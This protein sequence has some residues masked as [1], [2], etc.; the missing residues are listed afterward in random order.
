MNVLI[1]SQCH[2]SSLTETRRVLD[3][4]AERKGHRTWQTTI[5]QQG[6][7]TLRK[8]LKKKAKRSTAVACYWM[9][10]TSRTDL[11]WI[12][13]R[14]SAFNEE[15]A[16]PTNITARDVLKTAD[17]NWWHTA[18]YISLLAAI[19][20]LF[21][22]FG[23]ANILFQKK[24]YPKK[25]TKSDKNYEPYRHEWVSL[26]LFQ[27]FVLSCA[28]E[29]GNVNDENWLQALTQVDAEREALMV[30]VLHQ[31]HPDNKEFV[32]PFDGLPPA[33]KA[34]AWL[35]LSHHRLPECS[36][37][38]HAPSF[39]Y[40]DTW[41]KDDF[42]A[43]WNSPQCLK[44][45]WDAKA[46]KDV[47]CFGKGSPLLSKTWQ[48]RA[49]RVAERALRR[50]NNFSQEWLNEP[51]SL[52]LA[53]LALMMADHHYSSQDANEGFQDKKY[54][55]Y[56]NTDRDTK[57]LKQRLDE[58]L[59]G[60]Y[61]HAL[62]VARVLPTLRQS[63]PAIARHPIFKKRNK[64]ERFRWQDK[65]YDVA[66]GLREQSAKHGFFGVNV[67][68]TGRGKTLGNARIMYG[69]A[70]EKLGCRFSIA[71][72]L[73]TLTLQTG[74]ALKDKLKLDDDDLAVLI[75]SQAVRQLHNLNQSEAELAKQSEYLQKS[76]GSESSEDLLELGHYVRYEGVLAGSDGP[77]HR[78]LQKTPK[79]NQ[80]VSAPILV[81]TIDHLMPATE[82]ARGG[83]QIAPMLRLL[84]SD[85]V[86]DE[87]DD[88]DLNDL[89]A[90][91]RLVH[92]AGLLGSRV[93]LSSATLPP[94][95]VTALFEAYRE[96]RRGYQA[97]CGEPNTPLNI[98]CAWFD[99]NKAIASQH[100][101]TKDFEVAHEQFMKKRCA[102]LLDDKPLRKA[103]LLPVK[104]TCRTRQEAAQRYAEKIHTAIHE[105]HQCHSVS[106]PFDKYSVSL[107]LVR[108]ANINPL[109]AVAENL[110]S[111]RSENQD[112]IQ[113]HY[114][115]Y[116]S[117]HPLFVRSAIE[118]QLDQALSRQNPESLWQQESIKEALKQYP[119][120]KHH[121]FVVLASAVAE[122][123]RDHDYDWAIAE[124]S[125]MRSLIQL[126]GRIQ[127]HR[128][129]IPETPNLLILTQNIRGLAGADVAFEKPGF[130]RK[131]CVLDSHDLQ[132]I[133][134]LEQYEVMRSMPRMQENNPLQP[135]K[136]L[137]DLE[138]SQLR[139]ELFGKV[140]GGKSAKK[141]AA[142][143]WNKALLHHFSELQ[144]QT[145]FRQSE[146]QDEFLWLLDE[147]GEE[148]VIYR[149]FKD[150]APK[151]CAS[152]FCETTPELAQGVS[153]WGSWNYQHLLVN[154]AD[155]LSMPYEKVGEAFGILR[156]R[157]VD[158]DERP[159]QYDA[160]LGYYQK[161]D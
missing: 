36:P 2:K 108:I 126:A 75:G 161:L 100:E 109:V 153:F 24:I 114:C 144:R 150:A 69:L 120:K 111:L 131:N 137:A 5:T 72:G 115:I 119:D 14:T 90:L 99:E 50:F 154:L 62:S 44:D 110:L 130:E 65:A 35:V 157:K 143:W 61:R 18:E 39:K 86:L 148:L 71:L 56:A 94:A 107:G 96:G 4:F 54:K 30:S 147:D 51:F 159:W 142:L 43:H 92:W 38:G 83:K 37:D 158:N 7:V 128:C 40:C 32:S 31:D 80:L 85:L 156:L 8:M 1:I 133:L 42:A 123:G 12:V 45:D 67:A 116:H 98:S 87:P 22:D 76:L 73:R 81:S 112:D 138:H 27:A 46:L 124:P 16:V 58:H 145:R 60:V 41:W 84:T 63:L 26:R 106:D 77:M 28:D 136:N 125:S 79:L 88:F 129:Q 151:P 78:W 93:L 103:R 139:R 29:Q 6:L 155:T 102:K 160:H 34:V 20:A 33:A 70:D 101:R 122:V 25:K 82:G 15:G 117:Q 74:D 9:R 10:G 3:H 146:P 104:G 152:E 132:Q 91:T 48:G 19:A 113:I 105:L 121:C 49:K 127:R 135:T 149:C 141:Y 17:E 66:C 55:I 52:H 23:K 11:L 53:R 140:E 64:L 68:S 13:G 118:K 21:H 134:E 97:A 47:W 59:I 89:P 95:L 57:Q